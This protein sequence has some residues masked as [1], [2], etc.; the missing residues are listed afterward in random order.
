MAFSILI[1]QDRCWPWLH[2]NAY[3]ARSACADSASDQRL[4][5]L[6]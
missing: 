1:R 4:D 6:P 5:E 2:N 3:L